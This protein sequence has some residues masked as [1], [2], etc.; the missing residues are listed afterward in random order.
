LQFGRTG[1]SLILSIK[2]GIA[3]GWPRTAAACDNNASR[4]NA[5]G[6]KGTLSPLVR[7][8]ERLDYFVGMWSEQYFA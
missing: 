7:G 8:F 1:S 4:R 3:E 2:S 6:F 5:I